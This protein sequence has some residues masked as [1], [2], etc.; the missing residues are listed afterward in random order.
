M[1]T[2][3]ITDSNLQ[4]ETF[5]DLEAISHKAAEIFLSLSRSALQSKESFAVALSG[6][7]TPRKFYHLL[8]CT[9]YCRQIEWQR[10][11]FFW[12]DERCVPPDHEQSNFKTV[13]DA[14]LSTVPVP[15]ENIHRIRGEESPEEAARA[16]E[17]VMETFWGKD[18]MPV[19][20]LIVLGMG[21]DGHTASLFPETE[22]LNEEKRFAVPV[23]R[24]KPE[25]NRVT[26]TL[27]VLNNASQV[28]FLVSGQAKAKVLAAILG[29]GGTKDHYPA[30][31][32]SPARGKITWLID[33]EAAS[34]LPPSSGDCVVI[35]TER[36]LRNGTD[37]RVRKF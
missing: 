13:Y 16:Y 36:P 30:G 4:I 15:G 6:G 2:P 5:P 23:Y 37:R 32:V 9:P 34:L 33:Q 20:D 8:G 3:L 24:K 22:A 11:H 31:L 29:G 35:V 18:N 14:L 17:A 10:I 25:I 7:S 19:F 21:E 27:P 1:E 12:A 28:L 26:L